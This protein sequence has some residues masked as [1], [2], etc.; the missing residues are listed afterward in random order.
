MCERSGVVNIG[1]EG[2]M[3]TAAFVGFMVAMLVSQAMPDATPSSIFGA[4]PALLIGVLAAVLAGMLVSALHAWLIRHGPG[5][6]RSS[7]VRRS[8]SSPSG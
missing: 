1:I 5:R 8:T 2:M 7:A 6:T 3:L 4:T